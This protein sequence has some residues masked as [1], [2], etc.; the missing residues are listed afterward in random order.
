VGAVTVDGW[1]LPHVTGHPY[2]T[3]YWVGSERT[4]H[5]EQH[6]HDDIKVMI[7][8][9]QHSDGRVERCWVTP[10]LATLGKVPRR[11]G[12]RGCEPARALGRCRKPQLS[13]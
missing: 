7:D 9:V 3:R 13:G 11:A 4:I 8:G 12:E 10:L 5:I 2:A 1:E 6:Y